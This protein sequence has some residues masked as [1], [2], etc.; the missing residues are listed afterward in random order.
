M[1]DSPKTGDRH[2]DELATRFAEKIYGGAKGAI[3]LAVLQAD[4]AEALPDRPLRVLD[5]GA[6]LGHMSLWLAGRGH[7]VTLAEPAAP[8]L[9]GARQ[10]FEEAG[11]PATFIAAPWQELLGQLNEPYDLV[12]CHAVLE[13]LA[14]P[15]AI[16]PVLHQ[17]T[18]VDGWLSLAFYNRDALIY[19]NLLK[20]HFRKLRKNRFSGEGQSLTPQEP[21]DPRVLE[22]NMSGHWRIEA[23][24]GVRVFH[25]YMPVEFQHKAEPLDLVE[26]ELQYRRHPAFAGLGRY[27]HWLC[28]PQD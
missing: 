2:F 24:S 21:L 3:R 12:I 19:R 20:G 16:L 7:D 14:E 23:R 22:E 1:S 6:G 4:L 11:L 10:R 8:M 17:L 18:R 5:I 15:L 25:D 9:E 26:M 27:L 28:R 13:W